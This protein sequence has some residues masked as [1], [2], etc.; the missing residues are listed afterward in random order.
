MSRPK[1]PFKGRGAEELLA[2]AKA[3]LT[4]EGSV[5]SQ[6][7]GFHELMVFLADIDTDCSPETR[8]ETSAS[9]PTGLTP[10]AMVEKMDIILEHLTI[11]LS[12]GFSEDFFIGMLDVFENVV[13]KLYQPHYVQF[14]TFYAT[15]TT[16]KRADG[17]LSLLLNLLHDPDSDPIGRREAIGFIGSFVCRA[18]FL[19]GTHSARTAKYLVS[20]MHTLEIGKSSSDRILFILSLQTVCHMMCWECDRWKDQLETAELDWLCRS[21]R[22]LLAILEKTRDAGVLR[23][24]SHDILSKLHPLVGRLSTQIKAIVSEALMNYR[25]LLPALWKPLSESSLLKPHF[26]FEPFSNLPRSTQIFKFLFREWVEPSS[27]PDA[28]DVPLKL[29]KQRKSAGTTDESS[30]EDHYHHSEM[31]DIWSFHPIKAALGASPQTGPQ[32]EDLLMPS[33]F[34]GHSR[35]ECDIDMNIDLGD[36]LVLTRILSSKTFAHAPQ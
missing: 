26:P 10:E 18:A 24:V 28:N 15:S 9:N 21:K 13:L 29:G 12:A 30:V 33:P 20:F 11:T 3:C 19:S 35:S 8:I 2:Y 5:E 14:I 34:L 25:Q 31:D 6:I 22:G 1:P 16:K 23:L 27:A 32:E 36:N 4:G 7:E 17:F